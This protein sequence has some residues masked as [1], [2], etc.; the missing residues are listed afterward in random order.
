MTGKGLGNHQSLYYQLWARGMCLFAPNTQSRACQCSRIFLARKCWNHHRRVIPFQPLVAVEGAAA[1]CDS[2]SAL[3]RLFP[4]TGD[5]SMTISHIMLPK[6][7]SW[8]PK[9]AAC[10]HVTFSSMKRL[11]LYWVAPWGCYTIRALIIIGPL[12][13]CI[14]LWFVSPQ[15]SHRAS[16]NAIAIEMHSCNNVTRYVSTPIDSRNGRNRCTITDDKERSL[17]QSPACAFLTGRRLSANDRHF[18]RPVQIHDE[19]T[20]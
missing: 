13:V 18:D 20:I 12:V 2:L 8:G 1:D 10:L 19:N 9:A 16:E 17:V 5:R 11:Y 3:F 6:H 7:M 14:F 15:P 4:R